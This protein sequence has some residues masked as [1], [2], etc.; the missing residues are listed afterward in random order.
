MSSIENTLQKDTNNLSALK[1]LDRVE[2]WLNAP[3]DMANAQ[4]VPPDWPFKWRMKLLESLKPC[5]EDETQYLIDIS[6]R[7]GSIDFL[8]RK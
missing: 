7:V 2:S 5:G 3:G 8:E 4:S 6:L 1:F